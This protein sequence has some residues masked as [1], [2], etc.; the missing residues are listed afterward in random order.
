MS[1]LVLD[2]KDLHVRFPALGRTVQAV[3]GTTLSVRKGEI[4]GLVGESGSGKSIASLACLGL[5]PAPGEVRGSIKVAGEQIIGKSERELTP[6]RGAVAAMIF[7][8]PG[9]AL[10]PFFSIERQMLDIIRCHLPLNSDEARKAAIEALH[11]VRIPDPH[12]ALHKFPHQMS[13]GQ[14]QRVMIAIAISCKP[15][16]LIADEPTTALDVTVQAQVIVLLRDLTHQTGLSILFIT[17][18]LGVV[19]SLC[20]RICVLYAGQVV[21]SGTAEE[22]FDNAFH[23]YTEKLLQTVPSLGGGKSVLNSIAGQV[24]DMAFPP[25]GCAFHSRCDKAMNRC[26]KEQPDAHTLSDSRMVSCHLHASKSTA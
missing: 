1:D 10:N 5:V 26:N 15:Q 9:T 21:E 11:S 6:M 17:H 3:R 24:P 7:Q 12:L 16:L 23:P 14:L 2:I 19:A 18:D 4:V 8:N 20:D 22:I 25:P 13:G